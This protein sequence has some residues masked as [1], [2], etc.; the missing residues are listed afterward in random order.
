M[1]CAQY[2]RR[3][4]AKKALLRALHKAEREGVDISATVIPF[5]PRWQQSA[6]DY[7]LQRDFFKA[8]NS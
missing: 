8:T 6:I 2:I 5:L 7:Q 4:V 1:A 3:F